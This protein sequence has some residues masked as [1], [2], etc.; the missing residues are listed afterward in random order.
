MLPGSAELDVS[1]PPPPPLIPLLCHPSCSLNSHAELAVS[2][3]SAH[4]AQT[5]LLKLT[6]LVPC[7][8]VVPQDRQLT[9]QQQSAEAQMQERVVR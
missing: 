2:S 4:C 5:Y 1:T 7:P 3:R 6:P 9:E 8:G